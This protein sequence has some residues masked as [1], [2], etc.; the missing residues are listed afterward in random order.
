LR[1]F[2][3]ELPNELRESLQQQT[4]TADVLKV[5]SR[6]TFDLQAV[7]DTLVESAAR[8]CESDMAAIVSHKDAVYRHLA[9]YGYSPELERIIEERNRHIEPG[10]GTVAGRTCSSI[11]PSIFP[12]F[13]LIRSLRSLNSRKRATCVPCW[14]FHCCAKEYR[15]A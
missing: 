1:L 8:L 7:L 4:A 6:S 5:I 2:G 10:R 13:W 14:V 15:L 11:R 3:V 12:M 9:N